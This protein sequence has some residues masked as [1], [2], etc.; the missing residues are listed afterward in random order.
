AV[1]KCGD[2]GAGLIV[3]GSDVDAYV[4]AGGIAFSIVNPRVNAFSTA[5]IRGPGGDKAA[6]G[7]T[8]NTGR[9]LATRRGGVDSEF[10]VDSRAGAVVALGVYAG[11]ASVLSV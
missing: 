6:V 4:G 1:F 9:I 5:V 11:A 10:G 2:A 8:D 3:G 7:Q